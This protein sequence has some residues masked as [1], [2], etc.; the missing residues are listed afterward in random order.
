MMIVLYIACDYKMVKRAYP[1][2]ARKTFR[3]TYEVLV[4]GNIVV[5][6]WIED[7]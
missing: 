6:D 3:K 5:G 7:C 2:T 4:Q 1:K